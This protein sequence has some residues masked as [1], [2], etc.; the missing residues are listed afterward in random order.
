MLSNEIPGLFPLS[1][2][3]IQRE[4]ESRDDGG[5]AMREVRSERL[6]M[7]FSG[8]GVWALEC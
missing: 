7:D 8:S 1:V 2:G 3:G 6:K 4:C 5:G